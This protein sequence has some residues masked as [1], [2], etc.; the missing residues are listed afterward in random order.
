MVLMNG[1][2][3]ARNVA[4]LINRPT[5]GGNRKAG[6]NTL[7]GHPANVYFRLQRNIPSPNIPYP[8]P[9]YGST[10]VGRVGNVAPFRKFVS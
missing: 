9:R 5:G 2:K 3:K 7:V 1:S 6:I 8:M 4:S 10:S